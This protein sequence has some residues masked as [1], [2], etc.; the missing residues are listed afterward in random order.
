MNNQPNPIKRQFIV[1]AQSFPETNILSH[2]YAL[3]NVSFSEN[4]LLN[5][6][7]KW[8]APNKVWLWWQNEHDDQLS[9]SFLQTLLKMQSLAD[10]L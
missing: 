7:A 6:S 1:S 3:R 2:W 10:F 4:L 5:V 8:I 9:E